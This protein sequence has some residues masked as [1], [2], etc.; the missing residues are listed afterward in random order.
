MKFLFRIKKL[1]YTIVTLAI[2][3]DESSELLTMLLA[4]RLVT[5]AG[6]ILLI[7]ILKVSELASLKVLG[8]ADNLFKWAFTKLQLFYAQKVP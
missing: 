8:K 4:P 5:C 7:D 2:A 3:L 6:S 1:Y